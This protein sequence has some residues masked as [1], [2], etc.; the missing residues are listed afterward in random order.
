MV[1][2]QRLK[3]C[4]PHLTSW[5]APFDRD[6]TTFSLITRE[7]TSPGLSTV[8]IDRVTR[9]K[10]VRGGGATA[11]AATSDAGTSAASV[12]VAAAAPTGAQGS[13]HMGTW[14]KLGRVDVNGN[15]ITVV[16]GEIRQLPPVPQNN[17]G[18]SGTAT[19][20]RPH[21]VEPPTSDAAAVAAAVTAAAAGHVPSLPGAAVDESFID[22]D[23]LNVH[24]PCRARREKPSYLLPLV[25]VAGYDT[26]ANLCY[27]RMLWLYL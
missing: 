3:M 26:C 22:P 8:P 23:D 11:A 19:I 17:V 13:V 9:K 27:S 24:L 7:L 4:G 16:N 2:S 12:T 6:V 10:A 21:V 15:V 25:S 18:T 20:Y 14:R 5:Y 1:N